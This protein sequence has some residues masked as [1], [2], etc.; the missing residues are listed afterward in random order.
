MNRLQQNIAEAVTALTEKPMFAA[1]AERILIAH[2]LMQG[3][4]GQPQPVRF[5]IPT[6]SSL[7]C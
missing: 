1:D 3:N 6:P 5:A 4:L 2:D 7:W